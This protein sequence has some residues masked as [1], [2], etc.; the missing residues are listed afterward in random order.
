MCKIKKFIALFIV[1]ITSFIKF[2]RR[3]L[4]IKLHKYE[5]LLGEGKLVE[6]VYMC[7]Y[8]PIIMLSLLLIGVFYSCYLG[9]IPGIFKRSRF[10]AVPYSLL[11]LSSTLIV[12]GSFSYP[13]IKSYMPL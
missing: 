11:M 13:E 9:E 5:S 8:F 6:I 7:Y 4:R 2:S 3:F 12:K 1:V 10:W